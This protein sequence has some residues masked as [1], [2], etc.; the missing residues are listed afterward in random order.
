MFTNKFSPKNEKMVLGW[1]FVM[2]NG[3]ATSEDL[4]TK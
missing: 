3:K 2:E 4:Q 1:R